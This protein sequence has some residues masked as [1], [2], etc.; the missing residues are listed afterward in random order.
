M[1]IKNNITHAIIKFIPVIIYIFGLSVFADVEE[2]IIIN[3][4]VE[5]AVSVSKINSSTE[6]VTANPLTG[7]HNGLFSIFHGTDDDF[8]FVITSSIT[9]QDNGS[10]CAYGDDGRLLFA[11]LSNPPLN[12]DVEKAK[13]GT[14]GNKNVIAYPT[15]LTGDFVK[16]F[17]QYQGKNSYIIRLNG[18]TEG[19]VTHNVS[20]TPLLNTYKI[21]EDEAGEY[22][23]FVIFSVIPK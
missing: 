2:D 15:N 20:G 14:A 1:E 3:L 6:T 9:T 10:V 8:D 13:L 12:S 18:E 23:A 17:S 4:T 5:P 19:T 22:K 11:H 16:T 7:V 21:G